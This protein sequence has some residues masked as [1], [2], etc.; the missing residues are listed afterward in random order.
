M[1]PLDRADVDTDQIIPKQFLKRIERTGYGPFLFYDWRQQEDFVLNRPEHAGAAVLV[2]G[3]NFGCGSSREHA[4]WAIR[5]AGFRAVVAP[6]F[7][8]IFRANSY[9]TGILAVT[10]PASQVRHLLDLASEDA[11]AVIE[12]DLEAQEVRG[13]GFAYPFEI[14]PFV[15]E[16]L[17]NGLDEIGLVEKHS[18]AITDY[19]SH[20]LEWL[21]AVR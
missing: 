5:D 3:A 4:P 6:S 19:E 16:C 12:L 8:D 13:E 21:P 11:T 18:A 20:R 17:L 10:L 7:G 1:A 9:K 2:A 14:D 15:R